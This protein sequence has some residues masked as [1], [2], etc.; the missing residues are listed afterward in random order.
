MAFS[1]TSSSFSWPVL[2]WVLS[3]STSLGA[4]CPAQ[5]PSHRH[6]LFLEGV[7]LINGAEAQR[8]RDEFEDVAG[9]GFELPWLGASDVEA[10]CD[11]VGEREDH[12]V[13]RAELDLD[14]IRVVGQRLAALADVDA[15]DGRAL[16]DDPAKL[17]VFCDGHARNGET[18]GI[19]EIDAQCGA[20]AW[21]GTDA[22]ESTTAGHRHAVAGPRGLEHV[23]DLEGQGEVRGIRGQ[24]DA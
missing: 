16:A 19:G 22:A 13:V 8:R 10:S 15:L 6:K 11:H 2:M 4:N 21:I 14:A 23:R 5:S 12:A 18:A 7:G 1:A 3:S 9:I 20:V 17:A 24:A